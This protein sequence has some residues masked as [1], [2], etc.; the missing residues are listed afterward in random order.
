[1]KRVDRLVQVMFIVSLTREPVHYPQTE[2]AI[3]AYLAGIKNTPESVLPRNSLCTL[4]ILHG[5]SVAKKYASLTEE[6]CE[7]A[8]KVNSSNSHAW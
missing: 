1:M 6:T 4:L 2:N 5:T 8:V 3:E 7:S